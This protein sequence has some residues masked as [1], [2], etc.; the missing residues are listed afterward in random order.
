MATQISAQIP[1]ALLV[2]NEY[3]K[4]VFNLDEKVKI[5]FELNGYSKISAGRINSVTADSL[6]LRGIRKRS[7]KKITAIALKDIEKLKNFYTGARTLTGLLAMVGTTTGVF[8]LIDVLSNDPVFFPT[9]TAP[10]A[11]GTIAAGLLP[12]TIVTLSEPSYSRKKKYKFKAFGA[13]S[14]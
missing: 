5:K 7:S 11:V 14:K 8:M 12:Y 3:H 4:K 1:Q 2:E 6:Y 13:P 9:A 10:I